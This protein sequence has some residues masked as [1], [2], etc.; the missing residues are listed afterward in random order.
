MQGFEFPPAAMWG[1]HAA[2]WL[3][4]FPTAVNQ[5]CVMIRNAVQNLEG[6]DIHFPD[7][8]Y[9]STGY[10]GYSSWCTWRHFH[11]FWL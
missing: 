9:S 8:F 6:E 4:V 11:F 10:D 5:W 2:N 7:I 1:R 3:L